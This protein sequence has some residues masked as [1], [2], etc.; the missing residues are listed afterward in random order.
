MQSQDPL[1]ALID[2]QLANGSF[3]YGS[4]FDVTEEE[5]KKACPQSI[6]HEAWITAYVIGLLAKKFA[7]QKDLWELVAN[8]AK[9]FVKSQL[10][11]MDYDDL[12]SKVSALL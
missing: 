11:K 5:L 4:G 2:L 3:K 7:N 8:K 6:S 9:N 10:V 1:E 12:M